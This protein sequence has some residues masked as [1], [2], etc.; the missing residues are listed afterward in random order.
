MIG[1]PASTRGATSEQRERVIGDINLF[2][3]RDLFEPLANGAFFDRREL[4][5]LA[6]RA[7]RDRNLV[8][9]SRAKDELDVVRRL[10]KRLEQRIKRFL[11]QH[12][13]FVDDVNFIARSA[14]PNIDRRAKLANFF[15]STIAGAIDFEHVDVVTRRDPLAA[16]ANLTRLYCRTLFAVQALGEYPRGRCLSRAAGTAEQVRVADTVLLN[17]V[18]DRRRDVRLANEIGERLRTIAPRDYQILSVLR[19]RRARIRGQ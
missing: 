16:I 17:R 5:K 3:G 7:D 6:A 14:W 4:K 15:N 9:F 8:Q 18:R 11:G 10:F 2:G 1:C 12:V 13:D 19:N